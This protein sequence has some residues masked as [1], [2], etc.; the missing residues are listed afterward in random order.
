M[1]TFNKPDFDAKETV[2]IWNGHVENTE[3]SINN[4]AS[5]HDYYESK[6]VF[7][8]HNHEID[9][10]HEPVCILSDHFD[11]AISFLELGTGLLNKTRNDPVSIQVVWNMLENISRVYLPQSTAVNER[12]TV[13]LAVK[14]DPYAVRENG[15]MLDTLN[16]VRTF[17]SE[18]SQALPAF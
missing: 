3:F 9:S 7:D 4:H 1:H 16:Y 11:E 10:A 14:G 18:T 5:Q 12:N 6:M 17:L 8:S 13:C 2:N 15:V